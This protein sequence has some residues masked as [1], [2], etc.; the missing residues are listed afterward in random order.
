MTND[1]LVEKRIFR[2]V[3]KV[4]NKN[5]IPFWL[6][7]GTLLGII[8]DG[9]NLKNHPHINI[10][11][12]VKHLNKLENIKK[13]LPFTY[14]AIKGADKSGR[15]WLS[16]HI[17]R[18]KIKNNF[19]FLTGNT[20]VYIT[21]KEIVKDR[22]RW[23][24]LKTCKSVPSHHFAVLDHFNFRGQNYPI[25][26]KVKTYLTSRYGNWKIQNEFWF[27]GIDDKSIVSDN[28][29]KN[30]PI[31]IIAHKKLKKRI[32]LTGKYKKRMIKMLFKTL[33][34]LEKHNI[35]YWLDDGTLL[36]VIRD[37][38]LIPWDHD[39]DIGIPGEYA[40][41]IFAL[42]PKFLPHYLISKRVINTKWYNGNYRSAKVKTIREKILKINFHLDLFFKYDHGD[43]FRWVDCDALKQT[44][45]KYYRKLDK[46][47]WYGREISI[48]SN[49]EDYLTYN[50]GNWR[51]PNKYFDSHLHNGT[52]M[53]KGF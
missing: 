4:L 14:R 32:Q 42:A 34:I 47:T 12:D 22:S 3:E 6:E 27:R 26:S 9:G 50:F 36:G 15:E 38:D 2:V 5:K 49:V 33:D 25:P 1:I 29:I 23:V 19:K 10:G 37:G 39:A 46:I 43:V 7:S 28:I 51:E 21:V 41:Q 17:A 24:D 11:I 35:P 44:S 31:K 18:I 45:A 20:N 48:P 40:D 13:D 8:R 52:I 16:G 30:T 53:E